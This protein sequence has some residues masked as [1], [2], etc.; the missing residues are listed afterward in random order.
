MQDS[1]CGHGGK[2]R[3]VDETDLIFEVLGERDGEITG[4]EHDAA[5][6]IEALGERHEA[7]GI[8]TILETLDIF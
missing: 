1:A 3:Q 5:G 8:Q 4:Q 2:N 7:A 6:C